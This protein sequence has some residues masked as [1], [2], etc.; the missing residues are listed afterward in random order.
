VLI[1]THSSSK[2]IP[3]T[4]KYPP[5]ITTNTANGFDRTGYTLGDAYTYQ[6]NYAGIVTQP[7]GVWQTDSDPGYESDA[8]IYS[9]QTDSYAEFTF[10]GSSISWTTRKDTD[11]G[12]ARIFIDGSPVTDGDTQ[13]PQD[14]GNAKSGIDLYSA[15]TSWRAT[16]Y[17]K[18]GLDPVQTHTIRITVTGL[19]NDLSAGYRVDLDSVKFTVPRVGHYLFYPSGGNCAGTCHDGLPDYIKNSQEAK[20]KITCM[21]CHEAHGSNNARLVHQGED[22]KDASGVVHKGACLHC[23]DGSVTR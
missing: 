3:Y 22:Y 19:K 6:E 11:R 10:Q 18:S 23:H 17:Q 8:A 9:E 21:T 13:L 14:T 2:I 16:G 4:I 15:I 20:T 7:S 12:I 5:L 1:E